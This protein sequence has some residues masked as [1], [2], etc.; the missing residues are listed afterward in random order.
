MNF[1][2]SASA[3]LPLLASAALFSAPLPQLAVEEIVTGLHRPTSITSAH[4]GSGRLFVTEQTGTIRVIDKDGKL[5]DEPLL[6][7]RGKITKLDPDCCD[8]RGLLS[9]AFPAGFAK[10]GRFYVYYTGEAN[11]IHISRFQIRED[12]PN[13]ADPDSEEVLLRV[14]HKYENHFGG[15]LAFHPIDQLLYVSFGDGAG[16]ANPLKSSQDPEALFG[17]IWR[18]DAEGGGTLELFTLGLRNPWRFSFDQL[19][20]DLFIGDVGEDTWEEVNYQPFGMVGANFGWSVMEGND[21]FEGKPCDPEPYR[22]PAIAYHHDSEGCSVTS[23]TVYRGERFAQ[24]QGIYLYGDFCWGRIWGAAKPKEDEPWK[25]E[26]IL[27]PDIPFN[28]SAFGADEKGE[29]YGLDYKPGTVYRLIIAPPAE[30]E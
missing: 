17:K 26:M 15:Q 14:E 23:A 21:C 8:E 11:E 1:Y 19:T 25:P 29:I 4:D 18:W 2:R 9:V 6:D 20:G 5:L 16:G 13:R 28:W 27:S 24:L 7:V 12:N 10:S 30:P 3:L 22:A